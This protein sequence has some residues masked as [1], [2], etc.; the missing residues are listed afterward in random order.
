MLALTK[1]ESVGF[2]ENSTN[3]NFINS[4]EQSCFVSDLTIPIASIYE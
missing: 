4:N 3:P 2:I 1:N